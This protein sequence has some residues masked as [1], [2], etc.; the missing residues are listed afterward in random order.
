MMNKLHNIKFQY[1]FRENIALFHEIF[2]YFTI[3]GKRRYELTKFV[4]NVQLG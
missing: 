4:C 2:K 1:S 3:W